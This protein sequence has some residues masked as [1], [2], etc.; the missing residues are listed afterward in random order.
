MVFERANPTMH[1]H[2]ASAAVDDLSC[3]MDREK[4][5]GKWCTAQHLLQLVKQ[6]VGRWV[7]KLWIQG[8]IA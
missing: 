6:T 7:K 2:V 8:L 5:V 3:H 4:C 1:W